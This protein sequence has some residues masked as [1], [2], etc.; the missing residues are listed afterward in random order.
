VVEGVTGNVTALSLVANKK[1]INDASPGLA[2]IWQDGAVT[3]N[4][5][6]FYYSA[7]QYGS[8]GQLQWD[9]TLRQVLW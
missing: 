4:G 7:A 2:V 6:N 3:Q 9:A 1:L 5:S 8:S